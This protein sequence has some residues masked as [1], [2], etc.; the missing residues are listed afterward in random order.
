MG[1]QQFN[2]YNLFYRLERHLLL[3][4]RGVQPTGVDENSDTAKQY[5]Q[6]PEL[7]PLPARYNG[8]GIPKMWFL[9]DRTK[10]RSHRKR[11]VNCLLLFEISLCTSYVHFLLIAIHVSHPLFLRVS[12]LPY[13]NIYHIYTILQ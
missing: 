11:Y 9:T 7:P 8:V 6:L 1:T 12:A 10:K 13:I 2:R 5:A 3:H 4:Q